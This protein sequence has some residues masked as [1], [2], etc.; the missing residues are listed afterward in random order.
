[1]KWM[2]PVLALGVT[3]CGSIGGSDL[4]V[5]GEWHEEWSCEETCGSEAPQNI[6]GETDMT[7]TQDGTSVT[8]E[9]SDGTTWEGTLDGN[10]LTM[11]HTDGD[12]TEDSTFTF[13]DDATEFSVSSSYSYGDCTGTCTGTGT[14]R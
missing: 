4:D 2:I 3:A 9:D 8:R 11:S 5:S 6:P 10:E 7:L 12:Y 14:P 1:M 13:N